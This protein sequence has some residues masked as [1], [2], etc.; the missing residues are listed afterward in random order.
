MPFAM[1]RWFTPRHFEVKMWIPIDGILIAINVGLGLLL[2]IRSRRVRSVAPTQ[3]THTTHDTHG[4]TLAAELAS[5]CLISYSARQ[6]RSELAKI[7]KKENKVCY[8]RTGV[9]LR[10]EPGGMAYVSPP[11]PALAAARLAHLIHN[12]LHTGALLIGLGPGSSSNTPRV[13]LPV[14]T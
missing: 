5:L 10:F 9:H 12:S 7:V 2:Y 14:R 6:I 11:Y 3:H 8:H 1:L 4:T 13:P